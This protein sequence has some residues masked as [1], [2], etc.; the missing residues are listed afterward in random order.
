MRPNEFNEDERR[1]SRLKFRPVNNIA[2]RPWIGRPARPPLKIFK[3]KT[4]GAFLSIIW[5]WKKSRT[6]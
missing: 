2:I 6:L 1:P 4:I 3:K 5:K